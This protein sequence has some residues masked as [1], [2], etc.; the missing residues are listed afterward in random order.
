MFTTIIVWILIFL[1]FFEP[2]HSSDTPFLVYSTQYWVLF[3]IE[4]FVLIIWIIDDLLNLIHKITNPYRIYSKSSLKNCKFISE[5]FIDLNIVLDF[6]LFW[7]LYTYGIPY[8]RY[9]RIL[10]PFKLILESRELRR[11]FK[12]V[13][14]TLPYIIDMIILFVLFALIFAI[15]GVALFKA[16]IKDGEID[17][18]LINVFIYIYIYIIV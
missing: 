11:F 16:D 5:Y 13:V 10:R 14:A 8:F 9:G 7:S 18:N 15:I 12:S 2:T 1:T 6:I 17:Q 4:L 3:N